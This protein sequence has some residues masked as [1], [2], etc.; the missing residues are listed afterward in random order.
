MYKLFL[1]PLLFQID[2]EKAHELMLGLL[3]LA[4]RHP[5][6]QRLIRWWYNS[7]QWNQPVTLAGL[8]FPNR[9]GLAAGMD[10]NALLPDV[11][12]A[13]GFGFAELGTVT[14]LPQPGNPRPRLFRLPADKALINRMGF[15]NRG[16]GVAAARLRLRKS[17]SMVIGVNVGKNKDTDNAQAPRD[18]ALCVREL[19]D[20]ADY[21]TI[22]VSSPNTPGLRQL[23]EPEHLRSI[24]QAALNELKTCEKSQPLFVKIAPDLSDDELDHITDL[25]LQ[26]GISGIVAT[27]TTESREGLHTGPD[28]LERL[29][30]GGLSGAPLKKRSTAVVERVRRRAG[31]S[32]II[33]ASG[34]ILTPDDA[35]EKLRAGAN[36]VQIY[37]GLIYEGP[38][39]IKDI[40]KAIHKS[41]NVV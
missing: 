36:L 28:L 24:L 12:A 17:K 22:N 31:D 6:L 32:F 35:L 40:K 4:Q 41:V 20:V 19:R 38:S 39:L 18:Y 8:H 5:I 13:L 16:A 37:T 11:W 15:N 23:Q 26:M 21:F 1:R 3:R 9:V 29:G 25:C 7:E 33:I 30:K 10:K 2:P 27:N 34:G 14:P